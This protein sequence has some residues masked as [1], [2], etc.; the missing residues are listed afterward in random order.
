MLRNALLIGFVLVASST[1][2]MAECG[3]R[4]GPGYRGPDGQCLSWQALGAK[5][6]SPPTTNCTPER[7]APGADGGAKDGMDIQNLKNRA[8]ERI[9]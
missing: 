5:C 3:T 8:H 7:V 4:G 2:A 9:R 1:L 6:G